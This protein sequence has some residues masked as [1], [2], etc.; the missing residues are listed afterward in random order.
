MRAANRNPSPDHAVFVPNAQ[1]SPFGGS[2][3]G[4]VFLYTQRFP[5]TDL[6]Q[7]LRAKRD[8]GR[9]VFHETVGGAV[10]CY[11]KRI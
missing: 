3:R 1:V 11:A 9:R 4:W 5:D 6:S 8:F 7:A 10:T 2:A